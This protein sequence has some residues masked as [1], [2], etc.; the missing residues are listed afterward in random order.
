MKSILV[1]VDFSDV[2]PRV[3]GTAARMAL[4]V[5]ARLNLVHV[6]MPEA[7][8][9]AAS[10]YFAPTQTVLERRATDVEMKQLRE[11]ADSKVCPEVET[12]CFVREGPHV[13]EILAQADD[14]KADMIVMG[15]HGHGALYELFVG[16][17]TEGVLRHARIPVLIVPSRMS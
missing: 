15:S 5:G 2:T 9:S 10:P 12:E 3:V 14:T 1:C 13:D 16:S 6:V 4:G 11:L 7:A 8:F 17:V